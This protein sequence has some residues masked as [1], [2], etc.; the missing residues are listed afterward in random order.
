[1]TP[2]KSAF[3]RVC[4]ELETKPLTF[5]QVGAVFGEDFWVLLVYSLMDAG[6][7]SRAIQGAINRLKSGE[8]VDDVDHS[9]TW[10]R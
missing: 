2:N 1:V 4:D 8:K 9:E 5:Q 7:A 6:E 3:K 10:E